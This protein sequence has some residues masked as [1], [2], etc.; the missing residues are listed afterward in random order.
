MG[1][2]KISDFGTLVFFTSSQKCLRKSKVVGIFIFEREQYIVMEHNKSSIKSSLNLLHLDV[3][4]KI[5][6]YSDGVNFHYLERTTSFGL[7]LA[8]KV[9]LHKEIG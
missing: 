4:L 7:G 1:Y 2:L 8:N 6:V 3:F 9:L 5:N